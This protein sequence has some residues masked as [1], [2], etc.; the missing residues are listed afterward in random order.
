MHGR[1]LTNC[2]QGRRE[3]WGQVDELRSM[4]RIKRQQS[5]GLLMSV[6]KSTEHRALAYDYGLRCPMRNATISAKVSLFT[7]AVRQSSLQGV[8]M[9]VG[10]LKGME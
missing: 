10:Q 7:S 6:T 9:V 2:S 4:M 3:T 5:K 8:G 1:W